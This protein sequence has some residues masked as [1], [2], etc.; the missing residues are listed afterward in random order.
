MKFSAF[1]VLQLETEFSFLQI[2]NDTITTCTCTEKS[3]TLQPLTDS[4]EAGC[5]KL[6]DDCEPTVNVDTGG[7][8]IYINKH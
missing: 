8:N 4:L 1:D 5:V 3:K 2:V 6:E 7:E